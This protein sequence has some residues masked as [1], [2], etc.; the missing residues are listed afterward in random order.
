[1]S[2][3]QI[4]AELILDDKSFHVNIKRA[5]HNLTGLNSAVKTVD[6][7]T[8]K[9]EAG[10]RGWGKS[11]R[12]ATI[13][14]GGARAALQNLNDVVFG[15]QRHIIRAN[16]EVEKSIIL[17][18]N[19][20]NETS[21]L[22]RNNESAEIFDSI[23]DKAGKAPFSIR[24]LTDEMVKLKTAGLND[25]STA[26]DSLTDAV[27]AFGGTESQLH[28]ASIAIQQMMGKGVISM[29]ELRQQLGEAIPN[30]AHLMA[31]GLGADYS[32]LVKK[33]SE[34]KVAAEP[35]LIAMF[36]EMEDTFGGS[37]AKMMG[38]WDGLVA[39]LKTE[40][41]KLSKEIGDAGFFDGAKSE[42]RDFIE[43]L[44]SDEFKNSAKQFGESLA[45]LAKIIGEAIK[46]IVEWGPTILELGAAFL[47]AKK[48]VELFT[49]TSAGFKK[50][51]S[52]FAR[53][54]KRMQV[55][56]RR[57]ANEYIK[58]NQ[59]KIDA[60]ARQNV[61]GANLTS[62][63][64]K[65]TDAEVAGWRQRLRLMG[66]AKE[67]NYAITKQL[68]SQF[69][70]SATA[71][72]HQQEYNKQVKKVTASLKA[73][74]MQ[75]VQVGKAARVMASATRAG[76]AML[77]AFGGP[78][79]IAAMAVITLAY[80]WGSYRDRIK[81]TNAELIKHNGV[82]VV[83]GGWKAINE[84]IAEATKGVKAQKDEIDRI[85][86][87][88]GKTWKPTDGPMEQLMMQLAKVAKL[89]ETRHNQAIALARSAAAEQF[90][91]VKASYQSQVQEAQ[92]AHRVK[93]KN[94]SEELVAAKTV[95][96]K[97]AVE[98][99]RTKEQ[100]RYDEQRLTILKSFAE[101]SKKGVKQDA[102]DGKLGYLFRDLTGKGAEENQ[103]AR[104]TFFREFESALDADITK[105]NERLA[106]RVDLNSILMDPKGDKKAK[107]SPFE[108]L[109]ERAARAAEKMKSKMALG[110][111]GATAESKI[112]GQNMDQSQQ[113]VIQWEA[114]M[115][116]EANRLGKSFKDLNVDILGLREAAEAYDSQTLM[117]ALSDKIK[118]VSDST[119]TAYQMEKQRH[120]ES[121]ENIKIE[122]AH[123]KMMAEDGIAGATKKLALY[124]E[125]LSVTEK[126]NQTGT[127]KMLN[128]WGD[129]AKH[130]DEIQQSVFTGFADSIAEMTVSGKANFKDMADS[131]IKDI[132]RMVVKMMIMKTVGQMF[133]ANT[134]APPIPAGDPALL[135]KGGIMNSSGAVNLEKYATGGIATRPQLALFGEGDMAEA[136]VPLPDGRTIPVTMSGAGNA[137]PGN[138]VQVNVF[139]QT[140]QQ[141][142]TEENS[143]FDG[144]KF[145]VDVVMKNMTK[146][147]SFRDTVRHLK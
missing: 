62:A 59:E 126:S 34:G 100:I 77:G 106:G 7:S 140:G 52:D 48:S 145:I 119:L 3:N 120:A 78:A 67:A 49:A 98:A 108:Q 25:A 93:M 54:E 92:A 53:S 136:Y 125:L 147:G 86:A 143:R 20:S 51:S 75:M 12:D 2:A 6:T 111:R 107:K 76:S 61:A 28:R 36:R 146:P 40:T 1:M 35:A 71:R 90:S 22:A 18:K 72:V 96:E 81:E 65:Q 57:G 39:Q 122:I 56:A 33:I 110:F 131:I 16:A 94:L 32:T 137:K 134:G 31:Q 101:E 109:A 58:S 15:W 44:K 17:F 84:Q 27:A 124:Q 144:E 114:A 139:N 47:I 55:I 37:A 88:T 103:A 46:F 115:T 43:V 26:F 41:F 87:R 95:E 85:S 19:F 14:V 5:K 4:R 21:E 73:Q 74:Q 82:K 116:A 89:E 66:K 102:N 10:M 70:A 30:A 123:W 129:W 117:H 63:I 38:T 130:V 83:A 64:Q 127:A 141:V 91:I 11:L 60:M 45:V 9:A 13:I 133:G 24:A 23:I 142:E 132:S 8:R 135:A 50:M 97:A 68:H 121:V 138:N 42:L 29:E 79:G 80:E 99:K 128:E 113:K 112:F 118:E 104:E 105:L 69:Q